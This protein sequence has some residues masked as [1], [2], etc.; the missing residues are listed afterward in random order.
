MEEQRCLIKGGNSL[1][2]QEPFNEVIATKLYKLILEKEEFVP[3]FLFEENSNYYSCCNT[4]VS[5]NEE[6]VPAYYIDRMQKLRGSESLYEHYIS[7]C[8]ALGIQNARLK[9]IR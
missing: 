9:L 7:V 6:L 5:T 8:K 3:Y 1:N 4:M 2:N